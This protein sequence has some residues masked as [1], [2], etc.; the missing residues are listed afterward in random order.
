M[1]HIVFLTGRLAEQSLRRVLEAGTCSAKVYILCLC[2]IQL[3]LGLRNFHL[4]SNPTVVPI[5]S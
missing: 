2:L 1:E 3:R 5:L 4:R